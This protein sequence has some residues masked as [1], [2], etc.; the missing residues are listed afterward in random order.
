[1]LINFFLAIVLLIIAIQSNAQII[2]GSVKD[3]KGK[4]LTGAAIYTNSLQ[5]NVVTNDDGMY[6]MLLSNGTYTIT[7]KAI[8]Y[9][10]QTKSIMVSDTTIIIDFVLEKQLINES[11][12]HII[13]GENPANIV[14]RNA[15]KKRNNYNNEI[16]QYSAKAYVK[17]S[18]K[19]LK[20]PKKFMGKKLDIEGVDSSGNR[21]ASLSESI[22]RIDYMRPNQYKFTVISGRSSG[23]SSGFGASFPV[24]TNFY[25]QMINLGG[26]INPRGFVSPIHNNAFH[27]YKY[28]LLGTFF[29][30]NEM[31]NI[32]RIIPKRK[33]EPLFSGTIM[34]YENTWR[35][36]SIDVT[37]TKDYAMQLID[38]MRISQLQMQLAENIWRPRNQ[39]IYADVTLFGFNIKINY[40]SLLDSINLNPVFP[41][42]YFKK[43]FMRYNKSFNKNTPGYWDS[44][45][46]MPLDSIEVKDYLIKDSTFNAQNEDST[47]KQ[48][49]T[50][51]IR[52]A[53]NKFTL[54]KLFLQPWGYTYT[55]YKNRKPTYSI[56]IN[57]LI[58]SITYNTVEGAAPLVQLIFN[59]L[60]NIESNNNMQLSYAARYGVS[61]K[62]YNGYATF[63]YNKFNKHAFEASAGSWVQQ[64]NHN[65]PITIQANT[66]YTL[67]SKKNYMKTYESHFAKIEYKYNNKLGLKTNV[68]IKYET[69]LPLN[70]TTNY[71][72]SKNTERVFEPNYPTVLTNTNIVKH[73]A[74]VME[75][76]VQYQAGVKQIVLAS[77]T[78]I[79]VT[80]SKP[81]FT[82][83]YTKALPNINGSSIQY[84][85][86]KASIEG[87]K[88]F[89]LLGTGKYNIAALGFISIKNLT[90]IDLHHFNGNQI[91]AASTYLNSF[92]LAP[93]YAYSTNAKI[94]GEGHVEHHFNGLL[95]NKIPL[96]NKL[97]WNLVVASNT[98]YVNK[99][100]HYAELSVG[101]ENIFKILRIDFVAGYDPNKSVVTG[102]KFGAGGIFTR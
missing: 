61:N 101:L 85:K 15:I 13:S 88:N 40:T 81:I 90:P 6:S 52:K 19:I 59:K 80:S 91:A 41:K 57:P 78:V 45:R 98:F 29:E 46:P 99:N 31:V 95:T 16:S 37:T 75:G 12:V 27:Y 3:S 68:S 7:A 71:S 18:S 4:A 21:L 54:K 66:S 22:T 100:N 56:N 44:I 38:T 5:K 64:W 87:A 9:T 28:K 24:F 55:F 2:T 72:F 43:E 33:N 50:D 58:Q 70:N 42:N 69:R 39:I 17:G 53:T 63:Q 60:S 20:A 92:Q 89:K 35:I 86:W 102:V 77:G 8:G 48:S 83:A 65:N 49:R 30:N 82:L 51:S 1:M 67:F 36:H 97:K 84:N 47:G 62:R 96:L 74:F 94:F 34:I 14:I 11:E 73:K 23:D 25:D 26:G 79:P 76:Q 32:I 93:Y 10:A